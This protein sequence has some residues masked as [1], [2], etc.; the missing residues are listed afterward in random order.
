MLMTSDNTRLRGRSKDEH[1]FIAEYENPA[2]D[3]DGIDWSFNRFS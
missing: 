3:G 2:T 1:A